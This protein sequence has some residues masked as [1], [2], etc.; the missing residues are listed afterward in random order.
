MRLNM[1][2]VTDDKLLVERSYDVYRG[3]K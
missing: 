3:T 2:D 1:K